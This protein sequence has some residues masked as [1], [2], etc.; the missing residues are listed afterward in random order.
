MA[1]DKWVTVVEHS[2]EMVGEKAA[3]A[4]RAAHESKE[5]RR[6]LVDIGLTL[7]IGVVFMLLSFLVPEISKVWQILCW[8]TTMISFACAVFF[9]W[10]HLRDF[11]PKVESSRV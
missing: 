8:Q 9:T 3:A 11:H 10:I 4:A 2:K 5:Y 7:L 1:V 6:S